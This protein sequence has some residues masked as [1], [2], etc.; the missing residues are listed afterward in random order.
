MSF[1][2]H[3]GEEASDI[4]AFP[5]RFAEVAVINVNSDQANK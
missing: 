5:L 3:I 4:F 2:N 1:A